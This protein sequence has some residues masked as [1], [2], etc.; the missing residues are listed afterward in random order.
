M[1]LANRTWLRSLVVVAV[2]VA[3]PVLV[4]ILVDRSRKEAAQLVNASYCC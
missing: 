3:V 1:K 2:A 4:V